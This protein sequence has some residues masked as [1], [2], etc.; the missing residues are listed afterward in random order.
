MINIDNV[1]VSVLY[2]LLKNYHIKMFDSMCFIYVDLI[3]ANSGTFLIW[4]GTVLLTS[5]LGQFIQLLE[6]I[7]HSMLKYNDPCT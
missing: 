1:S 2:I 3:L 7:I 4:F 5:W 6:T